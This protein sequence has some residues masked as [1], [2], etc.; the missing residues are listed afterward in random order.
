MKGVDFSG[1][2]L[3]GVDLS[4]CDIEGINVKLEELRGIK[5]TPIQAVEFS[6][7]LGVVVVE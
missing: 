5:V 2:K 7:M 4:T 3:K 6:K 1:T